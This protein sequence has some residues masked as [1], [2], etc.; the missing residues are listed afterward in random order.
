MWYI[1][2]VAMHIHLIS[3][4]IKRL[5]EKKMSSLA[6]QFRPYH[7]CFSIKACCEDV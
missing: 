5:I 6:L 4:I 2:I 3:F 1:K 7:R